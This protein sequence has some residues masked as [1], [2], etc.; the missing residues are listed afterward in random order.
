MGS[1]LPEIRPFDKGIVVD[2][3]DRRWVPYEKL[4]EPTRAF[5]WS[6][7]LDGIGSNADGTAELKAIFGEKV[8]DTPKPTSL[9]RWILALCPEDDIIVL[10]SFAGSGTTGHAVLAQ[11]QADGGTR[12]FI[13]V[14]TRPEIAADV[15]A[16][17]LKRVIEGYDCRHGIKFNVGVGQVIKGWD[18]G[19]MDMKVG[20][21]RR[22]SIPAALGYGPRGIPGVIPANATLIFEVELLGIK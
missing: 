21:K 13:L 9:I 15:A 14:E 1:K 17:R 12:R 5:G 16:E 10:D 4:R 20:E 7:W 19:V 8:F 2:G 22:L 6:S 11:N 3:R 18:L